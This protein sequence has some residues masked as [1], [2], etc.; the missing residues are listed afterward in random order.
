MLPAIKGTTPVRI[1]VSFIYNISPARSNSFPTVLNLKPR[2]P[3]APKPKVSLRPTR[4]RLVKAEPI[5]VDEDE[6]PA[7]KRISIT[8]P[9]PKRTQANADASGS[10]KSNSKGSPS[11][12]S[13]FVDSRLD[14]VGH[15]SIELASLEENINH[16]RKSLAVFNETMCSANKEMFLDSVS[17]PTPALN[18]FFFLQIIIYL[19]PFKWNTI[20]WCAH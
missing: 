10:Q 9:P 17:A 12:A 5:D 18:S 19:G 2:N 13:Q 11:Y 3:A 7:D 8:A 6:A 15:M 4:K 1:T 14:M 20:F 16:L